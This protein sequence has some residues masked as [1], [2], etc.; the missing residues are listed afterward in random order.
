MPAPAAPRSDPDGRR[1]RGTQEPAPI[2][3]TVVAVVAVLAIVAVA[4]LALGATIH[5]STALNASQRRYCQVYDDATASLR[6][7]LAHPDS[8]K[9]SVAESI[10]AQ[11][12]DS[13]PTEQLRA[14]WSTWWP[15]FDVQS[16]SSPNEP[17]LESAADKANAYA[18]VVCG[19]P[20]DLL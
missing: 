14:V 10:F 20:G 15:L 2:A 5:R 17:A 3:L 8:P 1:Q 11:R 9:T 13:A 6:S 12:R 18:E 7:A 19:R 16:L 4:T